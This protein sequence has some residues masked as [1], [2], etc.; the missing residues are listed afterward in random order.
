[1]GIQRMLK[2]EAKA[3]TGLDMKHVREFVV[4]SL[5]GG[6]LVIV[7][8]YL[9]V[10]LLV[11]AMKVV[12]G[13]VRPIVRL[14]PEWLPVEKL[15]SFLLVLIVCFLVGAVVRTPAGR[16]TRERIEKVLFEKL[17][18]YSLFRS[19]TQQLTGTTEHNVWKP[20]LAE[21]AGA[22]VIAFV[23]EEFKDG[24]FAVF[25]P[26]APSPVSGSMYILPPERVHLVDV[27]FADVIRS[28]SR[29][30]S[31]S[32]EFIA[33]METEPPNRKAPLAS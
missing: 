16:A 11:Q 19:L 1:M 25:V 28:V 21:I 15:L 14:L 22:L 2:D 6:L 12:G 29:W 17:P 33:A 10:L 3:Y 27:P 23:I 8:I 32:E 24:R 13:L 18:G 5:V 20:A 30:G 4:T 31:G 26:S 7:P 9:S